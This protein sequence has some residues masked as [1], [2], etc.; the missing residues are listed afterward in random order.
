MIPTKNL[1]F[2]C[3]H[4]SSDEGEKS[5]GERI[6]LRQDEMISHFQPFTAEEQDAGNKEKEKV[7]GEMV[8]SHAA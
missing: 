2:L 1:S 4:S 6:N 3:S 8:S 7:R 5:S